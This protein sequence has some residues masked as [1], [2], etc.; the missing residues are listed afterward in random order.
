MVEHPLWER[1]AVGSNPII[2][3]FLF[4]LMEKITLQY[5]EDNFDDIFDQVEQGKSFHIMTP[6]GKDVMMVPNA[7]VIKASIDSGLVSELDDTY[8]EMYH[9]TGEGS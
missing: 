2:P 7:G 5:L 8:F 1:V 9:Q 6:D 3:I 4:K